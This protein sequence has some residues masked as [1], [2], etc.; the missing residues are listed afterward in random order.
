[1]RASN[2]I[3]FIL[4]I[5]FSA[6]NHQQ[7]TVDVAG[8][9]WNEVEDAAKGSTVHL[10]MWQGDPAINKYMNDF[11]VPKV[12]ALYGVNLQISGGQGNQIV[13]I[14]MNEEQAGTPNSMD[15]CWIN[16][17]TFYQLK[18]VNALYGP[19]TD[20]LPNAQFIDFKNVFI[21]TDFQQ[22]VNGMECPWGNVQLCIIYDSAKVKDPPKNLEE[23][24]S[25]MKSN[26]G[27]FTLTTDF[28]GL[29]ILKS[30]MIALAGGADSLKGSFDSVKYEKYSR[31]LWDYINRTKPYWW[32]EGKT[33]PNSVAQMHELFANGEL[34]FT[35]GNND[36]E[37]DNKVLQG[38]FPTTARSY[39]FDGGTIQN[40]H[41]MGILKHAENIAGAMVVCNFLIS[42]EAQY[43]K[44][45]TEVWGD[46]TV[47]DV[48]TLPEE[49]QRKFSMLAARK[50]GP[51][52][53]DIQPKALPELAPEYMIR[54]NDDFRKYVIEK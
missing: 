15:M 46:G 51:Q 5:T 16:G 49:W 25:F 4:L 28:T 2:F 26:P 13:A 18:Q 42:P 35:M 12:R 36:G 40:S 53:A 27:K 11:V 43:E 29:T 39:V 3:S 30:W 45:K 21:N 34:Y 17:E 23:L 33:F 10:M 50:Y 32:K 19:F 54:L 20:K 9:N 6:C 24:E 22:P 44:M 52:R 14:A 8:M 48:E 1:M 41:Y 38:L 37:V 7:H 31:Q 47:L